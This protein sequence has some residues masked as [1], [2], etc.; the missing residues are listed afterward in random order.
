MVPGSASPAGPQQEE[1]VSGLQA[2]TIEASFVCVRL[3]MEASPAVLV[4]LRDVHHGEDEAWFRERENA[5]EALRGETLLRPVAAL[6][7]YLGLLRDELP[8]RGRILDLLHS[9][10]LQ[11]EWLQVQLESH[12]LLDEFRGRGGRWRDR[13]VS[14]WVLVERAIAR[15]RSRMEARGIRALRNLPDDLPWLR[16]DVEK[17]VVALSHLMEWA[18]HRVDGPCLLVVEHVSTSHSRIDLQ[19]R[20][21][22]SPG[23]RASADLEA[24]GIVDREFPYGLPLARSVVH[25]Y[26]GTLVCEAPPGRLPQVHLTIPLDRSDPELCSA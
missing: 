25:H 16:V 7:G 5:G 11:S 26:G 19:I 6:R 8:M 20:V 22:P 1:P 10:D 3:D 14:P 13:P 12:A 23:T 17:W 4:S 21:Q 24:I 15:V 18:V 2:R 9:L